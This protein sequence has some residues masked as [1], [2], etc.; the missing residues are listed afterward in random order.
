VTTETPQTPPAEAAI[1]PPTQ[2][3]TQVLQPP[4][5]FSELGV[6]EDLVQGLILRHLA[7]VGTISGAGLEARMGIPYEV[8]QPILDDLTKIHLIDQS[9]YSNE[10]A[11][12]GRPLALRMNHTIS[13]AGRQRVGELA[14]VS[15]RYIGPC[16]VSLEAFVQLLLN[17]EESSFVVT[18]QALAEA[19]SDLE[20][21]PDILDEVGSAMASRASIF[22]YGPPGNGK[23]SITRA[24][25][26]LLG[27]PIDVP[28]AVALGDEIIRVLDPMY[29]RPVI[30]DQATDKR[31]SRVNRPVVRAGGELQYSQLELT[32]DSRSRYYEA[33]LQLKASGGVLVIDDFGRQLESP[34]RLLNR[35]I[36]PMEEGIDFLDLAATG[37]K[38]EIPF[39]CQLVFSTNLSPAQ[40]VDE[41]FL[42]RIAY[43]VLVSDPTHDGF[44]RIFKREADR[45]GIALPPQ[46]VPFVI[47]L[48]KN[49]P[50]RGNHPRQLIA[51]I[52]D[53]A[54]YRGGKPEITRENLLMAF[55]AYLNPAFGKHGPD[56]A[57]T[58]FFRAMPTATPA[59]QP[60]STAPTTV[61]PPARPAAPPE[62]EPEQNGG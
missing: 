62:P 43:K 44:A 18:P 25:A 58:H 26:K 30:S 37:H 6:S 40:L 29:H 53:R 24:M 48:Y 3:P 21:D 51:R 47:S 8:F 56:G 7:A 14:E 36:V 5:N 55:D 17:Q 27:E 57:E 12:E 42:R 2:V 23:S 4:K 9:G 13:T 1:Q 10:P 32:Y 46:A 28:Y 11:Q 20:L 49:R 50:L 54:R 60:L 61:P 15:T 35:F 33:P 22:L 38:I 59:P 16:P 45:A 52:V 31:F 19:L 41:A 39:T 34:A